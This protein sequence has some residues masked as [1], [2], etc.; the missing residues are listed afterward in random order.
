[1]NEQIIIPTL[2]GLT[3]ITLLFIIYS[4]YSEKIISNRGEI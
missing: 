3:F 2:S 4:F 1:M